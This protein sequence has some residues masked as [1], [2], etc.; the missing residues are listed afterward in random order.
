MKVFF[1]ELNII[2]VKISGPIELYKLALEYFP[3]AIEEDGKHFDYEINYLGVISR[4]PI[5]PLK[6]KL[7]KSFGGA[8]YYTWEDSS[9]RSY[10]YCSE[11]YKYG[12]HLI[13]REGNTLNI[14]VTKFNIHQK[15]GVIWAI[16]LIRELFLM[17][18]L[19]NGF[20]PVHASAISHNNNALIFFGNKGRGKTT[21]M[22]T[23]V[24]QFKSQPMSND[25]VLIGKDVTN[26][27]VVTGWAWRITVG[28]EL[29]KA[30]GFNA[31]GENL[32]NNKIAFTPLE[33]STY[34]KTSWSWY[35]NLKSIIRPQIKL[36]GSLYIEE[37]D[38]STLSKEMGSEGI[39]EWD[40][41]DYLNLGFSSPNF[42]EVF[43]TLTE[44]IYGYSVTGDIWGN[45]NTKNSRLYELI[46]GTF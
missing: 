29:L 27:W 40:F 10:S 36:D 24:N 20:I 26:K 23:F 35:S 6:T 43:K 16:R 45:S 32:S 44:E 46:G 11:E 37:I 2:K 5:I 22:F 18:G 34:T 30:S 8:P 19:L 12:G 42:Q 1:V 15:S 41:G 25:L 9:S 7:L 13:E 3:G 33:F 38:P 28:K 17:Q 14:W 39:E 21:S 31:N 4:S